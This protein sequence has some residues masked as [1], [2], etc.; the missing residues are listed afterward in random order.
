MSKDTSSKTAIR[1]D[2]TPLWAAGA[3]SRKRVTP[4]QQKCLELLRERPRTRKE[5]NGH[6]VSS[7]VL[8]HLINSGWPPLIDLDDGEYHLAAPRQ[9]QDMHMVLAALRAN[10]VP[11]VARY[12]GAATDHLI[13]AGVVR[14]RN[15]QVTLL[16][17]PW[18][19]PAEA[20]AI[21]KRSRYK[22]DAVPEVA[23]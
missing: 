14:V 13:N 15:L 6:G 4:G 12:S 23:T 19:V 8:D 11:P 21:R 17:P 10:E 18:K 20:E 5:L 9:L 7:A 22:L 3:S 1:A 2:W 16:D